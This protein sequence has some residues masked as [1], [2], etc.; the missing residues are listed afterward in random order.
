MNITK[1]PG[2]KVQFEVE[3][4]V[5]TFKKALDEAYEEQAKKY[6]IPGFRKGHVPKEIFMAREGEK[7]LY[8]KAL[9]LVIN[10][11]YYEVIEKENLQVCSQPD[12]D[13]DYENISSDKPFK[14]T[15]VV[16]VMPEVTLGE[17][18]GLEVEKDSAEVSDAEVQAVI[19][20]QL[21]EDTMESDK[22]DHEPVED[23][24]KVV[25]D[26]EGSVDGELFEGGSAKDHE[27]VIGSH[28]FI[29]GFEE[30]LIGM[31]K[32]EVK[33]INVKFPDDYHAE[34]LKGKDSVFKITLHNIKRLE[35]PEFNDEY[36]EGL[37]HEGVKTAEE[38]RAHIKEHL[39]EHKE[40]EASEKAEKALLE[41]IIA[42][43]TFELPEKLL[44]D[45]ANYMYEE[46][47]QSFEQQYK[48]FKFDMYLS[49]TGQT[50]ESH[51]E[52]LK[53]EAKFR[54]SRDFVLGAI[55]KA[56]KIETTKEELEKEYADI[57][58]YYSLSVDD[59][60]ARLNEERV[61]EQVTMRKA[62]DFV[63]ENNTFKEVKAEK[64]E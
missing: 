13:L 24:D 42:N 36:V 26:F 29:P 55:V 49:Y 51:L 59:V 44:A 56:E 9:D 21:K 8:P 23:G 22:E 34:N 57:A 19:D 39:T 10:D 48:G 62:Y 28:S 3:V 14:Y 46:E 54:L 37:D 53:E 5:E 58:K 35:T 27:L 2:S 17:Y 11:T 4:S 50:K 43:A 32:G 60:K 61:S 47:A 6:E 64:A 52:A 30:Q 45:E 15:V 38:Y 12:I 1:L 41:K 18:K 31:K 63:K 25:I 7:S 40:H 20:R 33:D 16:E